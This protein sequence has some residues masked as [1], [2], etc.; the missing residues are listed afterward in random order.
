MI[1]GTCSIWTGQTSMH[2]WQVVQDQSVA[3]EIARPG[4]DSSGLSNGSASRR[5]MIS[6]LGLSGRADAYAGQTAW[7]PP[8]SVQAKRSRICFRSKLESTRLS[9]FGDAGGS[10]ARPLGAK[11]RR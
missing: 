5:S 8:H 1:F 6:V 10:G 2:A 3:S 7:H 9:G 4:K 11:L